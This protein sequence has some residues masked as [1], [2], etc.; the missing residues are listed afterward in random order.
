LVSRDALEWVIEF[1]F[2][3]MADRLGSRPTLG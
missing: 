3:V 1:R 2:G